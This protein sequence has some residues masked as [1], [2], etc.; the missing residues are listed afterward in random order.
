MNSLRCRALYQLHL[1]KA[2]VARRIIPSELKVVQAFGCISFEILGYAAT[3][4][5]ILYHFKIKIFNMNL[6]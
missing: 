5:F 3:L 6:L 4:Y 1:V 2:E